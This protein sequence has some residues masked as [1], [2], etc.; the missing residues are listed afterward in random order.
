MGLRLV[1]LREDYVAL[2]VDYDY[3]VFPESYYDTTSLEEAMD[4]F[5]LY[6]DENNDLRR[7]D[8][9][10]K[11]VN[12]YGIHEDCINEF[13][14]Q[15]EDLGNLLPKKVAIDN[16]FIFLDWIPGKYYNIGNRVYYSD[17]VYEC[18]QNHTAHIGGTPWDLPKFWKKLAHEN[19]VD[20]WYPESSYA[21]YDKVIY[22][23]KTWFSKIDGNDDI[24]GESD[25]WVTFGL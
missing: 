6:L 24:P 21:E 15:L 14:Q 20:D 4:Y 13:L 2:V 25:T 5:D 3:W 8:L 17:G 19:K 7:R 10:Q 16:E 22:L 9:K 18:L 23:G 11:L 1:P 12:K